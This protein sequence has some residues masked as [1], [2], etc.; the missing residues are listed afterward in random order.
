MAPDTIVKSR[1]LEASIP[2]KSAARDRTDDLWRARSGVDEEGN[3]LDPKELERLRRSAQTDKL[4]LDLTNDYLREKYE[5]TGELK[6]HLMHSAMRQV[7]LAENS[8]GGH[9]ELLK[10]EKAGRDNPTL[11]AVAELARA[12]LCAVLDELDRRGFR[13]EVPEPPAELEEDDQAEAKAGYKRAWEKRHEEKYELYRELAEERRELTSSGM[14]SVAA[15]N[16]VA[17]NNGVSVSTVK[18]AVKWA[19][20]DSGHPR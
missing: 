19:R 11:R 20:E 10:L 8:A 12:G 2:L 4:L 14:G 1:H 17:K 16:K 15:T 18:R 9:C 6:Y 13:L 7:C 5:E 3:P